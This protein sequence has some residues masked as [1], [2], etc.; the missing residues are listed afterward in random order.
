MKSHCVC[1]CVCA[2]AFRQPHTTNSNH[3]I[4]MLTVESSVDFTAILATDVNAANRRFLSE[5]CS[6]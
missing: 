5:R 2:H 6:S 4:E 1:L 3:L